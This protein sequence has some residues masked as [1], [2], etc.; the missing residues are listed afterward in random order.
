M[1]GCDNF[2]FLDSSM[3]VRSPQLFTEKLNEY[4]NGRSGE[5]VGENSDCIKTEQLN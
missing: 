3:V 4:Q 2:N 1:A 5:N